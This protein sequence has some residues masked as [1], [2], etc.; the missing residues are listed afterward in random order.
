MMKKAAILSILLVIFI[1]C[2]HREK[3]QSVVN[4]DLSNLVSAE[5]AVQGMTCTHCEEAIVKGVTALEGVKEAKASFTEGKAWVTYDSAMV[6]VQQ[7]ADA[8]QKKGYEVTGNRIMETE[9]GAE[10]TADSTAI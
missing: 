3:S 1:S 7:L 9:S 4:S 5:I 2:N 6:S 10:A 8:I